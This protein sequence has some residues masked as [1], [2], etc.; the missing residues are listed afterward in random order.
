MNIYPDETVKKTIDFFLE[1]NAFS[2]ISASIFKYDKYKENR[3]DYYNGKYKKKNGYTNVTS[4]T[5][6]DLASLTKPFVTLL[7]ILSLVKEKKVRF[8]DKLDTLLEMQIEGSFKEITLLDLLGHR[9]GLSSHIIFYNSVKE[10]EIDKKRNKILSNILTS[11]F[12]EKGTYLYSDLDYILLGMIIER[13]TG[14]KLASFWKRRILAYLDIESEFYTYSDRENRNEHA[15]LETGYCCWSE[16]LLQGIV[17]DDNCRYYG[18]MMGHAGLFATL[19]GVLALCN[20]I[21]SMY[22]DSFVYPFIENSDFRFVIDKKDGFQPCFGFDVP[23]GK[24]PSSGS[25]FSKKTIGHLGFTGTS[26][27][28]DLSNKF[29]IVLLTNRVFTDKKGDKIRIARPAIHDALVCDFFRNI[30]E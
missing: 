2:G 10:E 1:N 5:F 9:S 7:S 19:N 21:F 16:E 28:L 22:Y 23:T 15:F 8:S 4:R 29:G 6:F 30:D 14:M 25:F 12:I 18:E 17:H 20:A 27:W 13:K 11:R 24:K 26:F 3:C